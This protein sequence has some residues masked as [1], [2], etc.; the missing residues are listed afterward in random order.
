MNAMADAVENSEFVIMCMS[1]SYKQSTYCQAEAEYAF[2]FGGIE[3]GGL[4]EPLEVGSLYDV[5]MV[6]LR[7][8]DLVGDV[9]EHG[10]IVNVLNIYEGML[11][12][13]L[14]LH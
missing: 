1:D 14:I 13:V 7:F 8:R 5:N 10:D 6:A 4:Y 11:R 9:L 2:K 12:M 3:Q